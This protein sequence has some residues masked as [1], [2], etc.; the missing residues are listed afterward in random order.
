MNKSF[1]VDY[2]LNKKDFIILTKLFHLY[3]CFFHDSHYFR[4]D[5][6][7]DLEH[8]NLVDKTMAAF[9]QSAAI[10]FSPQ[11]F[12]YTLLRLYSAIISSTESTLLGKMLGGQ[13]PVANFTIYLLQVGKASEAQKN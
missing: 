12:F 2:Q 7:S 4:E 13:T 5:L 11:Q 10:T 6:R 3:F 9:V 8:I 1:V